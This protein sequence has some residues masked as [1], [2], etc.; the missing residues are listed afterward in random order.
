MLMCVLG[1]GEIGLSTAK[2]SRDRGLKVFGYDINEGVAK[3]ANQQGIS[4]FFEWEKV[5]KVDVFV[6]C[7]STWNAG[8]Q[9]DL[10]AVFD[11]SKKISSRT[12]K[13]SLVSIESTIVPGVSRK[14]YNSIFHGD[15]KL[16]H[17]PHRYW[18]EDPVAHGVRQLRVIGAV[19]QDSL[20][21]GKEF[22]GNLLDIPLHEVSSIEESEM[23]KMSE[24]AYR[25]VQIAFAEELK[26]ICEDL[27]LDFEKVREAC[28]TKWNTEILD[29][30]EGIQGKCLPKDRHSLASLSKHNT[31][32][33]ASKKVDEQYREWLIRS[34][35]FSV[36]H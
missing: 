11:I 33:E 16:V 18:A 6:I 31:L 14:I 30:R 12:D 17:V 9:P 4:A 10:S 26:M 7:V 25:Y 35:R 19:N 21:S 28:N 13:D 8:E 15:V 23:C 29:A 3:R 2:H 36:S 5:P 34:K 1:L 32:L 24:N 20:E 22:Y 27:A